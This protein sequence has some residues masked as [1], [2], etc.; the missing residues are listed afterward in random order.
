MKPKLIVILG[1]TASGKSQLGIEVARLVAGEIICADSRT[2]YRGMNIGT[3]K[4]VGGKT[5]AA[6]VT[7]ADVEEQGIHAAATLG[8]KDLFHEKPYVVDGVPHWG[9][10]ILDPDE[11]FTAA[12]FKAYAEQ[13]IEDMVKRGKVPILLGGTGLYISAVVDNLSFTEGGEDKE[14]R[15]ELEELS[16]AAL[17]ERLKNIDAEA[18]ETID[19]ANR[20]RVI[21]A[22]EIIETTGKPLREQQTK[23]EE[24]YDVLMI[25]LNVDREVL[26]ERIDERVDRMIAE[27][28]VDEVRGL[29][30]TYGCE[31][32]AMTGIGYRQICAFLDGYMKLRDAIDVVKRETRQY[33]KRQMTWFKRDERIVWVHDP[34]M[35][36]DIV[37]KWIFG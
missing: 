31:V 33:A 16:A 22:I 8:I 36:V 35:A 21:R 30:E 11:D 7:Q 4:P 12:D 15:K 37:K 25:G 20:R 6:V 17:E 13:K 26:H 14:L 23:G 10:D 5:P 27:G 29:K 1:P 3:A 24:Q 9:I 19:L 18:F 34:E 32:N 2:L 28:L